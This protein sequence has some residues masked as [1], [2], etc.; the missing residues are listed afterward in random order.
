MNWLCCLLAL[1]QAIL[2]LDYSRGAVVLD[3]KQTR[4]S[5][6]QHAKCTYTY[7]VAVHTA[8]GARS[9]A[10]DGFR[11]H[12]LVSLFLK[13]YFSS[14]LHPPCP[15]NFS[16]FKSS[17]M[18]VVF[19]TLLLKSSFWMDLQFWITFFSQQSTRYSITYVVVPIYSDSGILRTHWRISSQ[20][21]RFL[22]LPIILSRCCWFLFFL[23]FFFCML[24]FDFR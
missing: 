2:A 9:T 1:L 13:T 5:F 19:C 14:T 24:V 7:E 12:A 21:A 18:T 8:R 23:F 22:G 10:S 4:L 6:I 3:Q 16:S 11:V 20:V 17:C 15:T